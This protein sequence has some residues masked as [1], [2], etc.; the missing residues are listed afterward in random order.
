MKIE[1]LFSYKDVC[2]IFRRREVLE[3]KKDQSNYEVKFQCNTKTKKRA[4]T[5]KKIVVHLLT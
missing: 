5:K 1:H 4:N 2:Q 3:V